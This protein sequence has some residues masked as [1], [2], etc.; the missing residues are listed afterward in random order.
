MPAAPS[1]VHLSIIYHIRLVSLISLPTCELLV[2]EIEWHWHSMNSTDT[3][4]K[5][6]R[7]WNQ[8]IQQNEGKRTVRFSK[9]NFNKMYPPAECNDKFH[10]FRINGACMLYNLNSYHFHKCIL[11]K[12]ISFP[13]IINIET[14]LTNTQRYSRMQK[15]KRKIS[16][17]NTN[18]MHQSDHLHHFRLQ[19]HRN[20]FKRKRGKTSNCISHGNRR[21]NAQYNTGDWINQNIDGKVE[22]AYSL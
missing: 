14:F 9:T 12:K 6:I 17:K 11:E 10:K 7:H 20:S 8:W 1:G 4:C 19:I 13:Q 5:R 15:W 16:R 2:S 18:L 21:R 3:R 22:D